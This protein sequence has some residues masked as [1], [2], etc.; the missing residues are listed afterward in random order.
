MPDAPSVALA[1]WVGVGGRDEPPA[2]AGASHFLEHLLF[3]GTP[4]LGA[5]E[6][7]AKVD[8]VGGE[9][10]AYTAK[11]HTA[12][13]LRVPHQHLEMA[14]DL[15]FSVVTEPAL[16]AEEVDAERE[17][18]LEELLL[19]EDTPDDLVHMQLYEQLFPDHPLGW[20]VLGSPVTIGGMSRDQVAGFFDDWYRPANVVVAAAGRMEHDRLVEQVEKSFGGTGRMG[21]RPGRVAPSAPVDPLRVMERPTEQVHIAAGYRSLDHEDPDHYAL[22]VVNHAFGGGMSS[23]LFHEIRERRGLAYAVYSSTSSYVDSGALVVYTGTAPRH[24]QEVLALLDSEIATLLQDGLTEEELRVAKGYL[25]GSML[26]GLEDTSGRMAR[27]GASEIVRGRVPPI[28][29]HLDRLAA[30][31]LDDANRVARRVLGGERALSVV[32]PVGASELI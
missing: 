8:A 22:A 23:R 16:R 25:S 13:Y 2:L 9:M 5:R 19:A 14:V 18:I 26:L 6:L 31:T 32:G 17:V 27:I 4:S 20:E 7:A 29:E 21:D 28:T 10:N 11:E 12:Y 30:V 24:A 3:K 15:L 1:C